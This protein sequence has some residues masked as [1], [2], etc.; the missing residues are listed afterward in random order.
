M[1]YE[2]YLKERKNKNKVPFRIF[3]KLKPIHIVLFAVLFFV[4][5]LIAKSNQNQWI[6]FV[7][8]GIGILYIFSIIKQGEEDIRVIP[9]DVAQE[10]ARQDLLNEVG[11][12]RVFP[13]G[14]EI[15]PLGYYR[16]QSW[17]SG[18]GPKLFKYNIG[19]S[20]KEPNKP[21][22]EIIYQMNPYTGDC[23]GIVESI[24]GFS[25]ETLKDIQFIFPE[26]VI[27]EEKKSE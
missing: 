9:R 16:D 14:T 26:K 20:V 15:H 18:D 21:S 1:D 11:V 5:T 2:Q 25:G 6:Y 13:H 12:G 8:G 4:G 10:I 3:N 19:F 22:R 27:K 7:L 24:L 23:K 17:D